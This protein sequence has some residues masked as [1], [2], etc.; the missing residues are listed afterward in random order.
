[1]I[2]LHARGGGGVVGLLIPH[3]RAAVWASGVDC[4]SKWFPKN[5]MDYCCTS[6]K[7]WLGC[8]NNLLR[9]NHMTFCCQH[10]LYLMLKT[11]LKI[12]LPAS[13]IESTKCW[14]ICSPM[15]IL[16][17]SCGICKSLMGA[18]LVM[19]GG[20]SQERKSAV[21]ESECSILK[22]ARRK[23]SAIN[24]EFKNKRHHKKSYTRAWECTTCFCFPDNIPRTHLHKQCFDLLLSRV[25]APLL[26]HPAN[27]FKASVASLA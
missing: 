15:M 27:S 22:G 13:K 14:R 21:C 3:V 24:E 18:L 20:V 16:W 9:I 8:K 7:P 1:M 11:C 10:K 19:G 2:S 6:K 23:R 4:G 17:G 25:P 5:L 26:S 12:Q